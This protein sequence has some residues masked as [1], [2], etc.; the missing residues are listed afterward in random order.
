MP[1]SSLYFFKYHINFLAKDHISFRS[2]KGSALRGM[3]G[4]VLRKL[5]CT[6]KKRNCHGCLLRSNC[7]YAYLFETP[8][9]EDDPDHKRY[10][11]APHPYIITP[12]LIK[13]GHISPKTQFSCELILIG[14]AN[15]YLPYFVYT[16]SEMGKLGL[17]T[18][19]RKFRLINVEAISL[20]GSKTEVYNTRDNR[21]KFPNSPITYKDIATK[22]L[23]KDYLTLCFST[24]VRIKDKGDLL[25][26]SI[27]FRLLIERLY[28]RATLLSH[29]HCGSEKRPCGDEFLEGADKVKIKYNCLKWY[30]WQRYSKRK[31]PMKLGGLVGHITY[32]GNLEKFYPLLRVGEYIHVGKAV[33]FGLGKYSLE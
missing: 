30:D 10:R 20:D 27:P 24:P 15:D 25:S 14:K 23:N 2:Y 6:M 26:T 9:S 28:E 7:V 18:K 16:F 22:G 1:I 4:Y 33:T 8:I 3:F 12:P 5:A 11:N 13:E 21:L 17:G 19:R 31:G 32:E 29:Y